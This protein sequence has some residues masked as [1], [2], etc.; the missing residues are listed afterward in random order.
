MTTPYN[1]PI[2]GSTPPDVLEKALSGELA[3]AAGG[4]VPHLDVQEAQETAQEPQEVTADPVAPTEAPAAPA[5]AQGSTD[6][7]TNL[8]AAL[9]K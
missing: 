5:P 7:P 4:D 6:T 9:K 1:D 3:K 8:S 2:N